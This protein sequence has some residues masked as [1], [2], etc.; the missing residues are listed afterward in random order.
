[1]QI[2]EPHVVNRLQ[3]A[4]NERQL[5]E[6]RQRVLNRRFQQI[7]NRLAAILHLQRFVVVTAPAALV[8]GDIHIR[9]EVHLNALQTIALARLA[10][11]AF[12]VETEAPHLVTAFTRFGE[13]RVQL[14]NRRKNARISGRIRP[15]RA[16]DRRLV[17]LHD[18][19]DEVQSLNR[20]M[21]P[22]LGMRV[23]HMLRQRAVQ[24]VVDQRRLAR[25]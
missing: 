21:Q 22:R 17:D 9:Q 13:H 3:F 6:N 23:V 12:D 4:R 24:N 19:V 7:R 2:A 20:G 15:R 16:P 5:V 25:A 10:A 18:F 14:A 1:M 8:A 11:P